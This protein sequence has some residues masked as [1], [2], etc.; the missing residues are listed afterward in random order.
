MMRELKITPEQ[1]RLLENALAE[2]QMSERML[3]AVFSAIAA[4]HGLAEGVT[5]NEVNS[6]TCTLRVTVPDAT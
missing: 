4:G 5:L 1:T 2:K 6:A 3:A